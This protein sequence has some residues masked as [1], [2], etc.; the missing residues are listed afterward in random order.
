MC[1]TIK[2]IKFTVLL[3]ESRWGESPDVLFF[4]LIVINGRMRYLEIWFDLNFEVY[5]C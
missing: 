3:S 5:G 4:T 1:K 2:E